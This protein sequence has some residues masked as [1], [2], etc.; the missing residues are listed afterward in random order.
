MADNF[1][2]IENLLWDNIRGPNEFFNLDEV[3]AVMD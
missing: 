3:G 1:E 2:T